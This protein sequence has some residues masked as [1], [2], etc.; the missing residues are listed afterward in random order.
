MARN[1]SP[2]PLFASAFDPPALVLDVNAA[3]VDVPGVADAVCGRGGGGG[4]GAAG[5]VRVPAGLDQSLVS[6]GSRKRIQNN[7]ERTKL[8]I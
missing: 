1:S 2:G 7:H 6:S 8:H 5:V 3:V 4:G